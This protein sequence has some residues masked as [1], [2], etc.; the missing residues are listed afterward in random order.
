MHHE[1]SFFSE[2]YIL[3]SSSFLFFYINFRFFCALFLGAGVDI[4][5]IYRGKRARHQLPYILAY[6]CILFVYNIPLMLLCEQW[7]GCTNYEPVHLE[8]LRNSRHSDRVAWCSSPPWHL[9][10]SCSMLIFCVSVTR[11]SDRSSLTWMALAP[12]GI[13]L[14]FLRFGFF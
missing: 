13:S 14:Y 1:I 4:M 10:A 8:Q 9:L 6:I 2:I 12:D 7:N 11:R 5:G 3:F